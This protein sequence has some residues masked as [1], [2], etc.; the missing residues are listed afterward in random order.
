[1]TS[2]EQSGGSLPTL[3]G[4]RAPW[5]REEPSTWESLK[6]LP[7][8]ISYLLR[9][10]SFWAPESIDVWKYREQ[11]RQ[12]DWIALRALKSQG[13]MT[14]EELAEWLNRERRLRTSPEKTGIDAVSTETIR[15]WIA[16]A[17]RRDLIAPWPQQEG[18][19]GEHWGLSER[20]RAATRSPLGALVAHLP[21]S[22]LFSAIAGGGIFAAFGWLKDHDTVTNLL[23]GVGAVVLYVAIIWLVASFNEK[24][25]GAGLAV[26]WIET[27]R[28]A[29]KDFPP[30]ALSERSD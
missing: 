15:D 30:L 10:G 14:A 16:C 21:L 4:V 7:R 18:A 24:R 2:T 22:P 25:D 11:L 8:I 27:P 26:V 17:G 23:I 29:G 3:A 5:D 13:A 19:P 12:L 1:M 28:T 20:G 6:E 9:F